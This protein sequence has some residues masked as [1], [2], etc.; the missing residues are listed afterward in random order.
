MPFTVIRWAL[1]VDSSVVSN[2][3]VGWGN[4]S[5]DCIVNPVSPKTKQNK[6]AKQTSLAMDLRDTFLGILVSPTEVRAYD[7]II[8][9]QTV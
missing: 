7:T 8:D 5:V 2:I 1:L 6:D 3:K 4:V 9:L